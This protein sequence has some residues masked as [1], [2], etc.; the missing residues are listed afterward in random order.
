MDL[1]LSGKAVLITGGASGLGRET[2]RYMADEG[3][4]IA[5]SDLNAEGVAEVVSELEG[6]GCKAIGI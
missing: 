4:R 2:A 1:G 6:V 5:I 3:A